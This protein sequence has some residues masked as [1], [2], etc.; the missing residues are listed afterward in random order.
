[1]SRTFARLSASKTALAMILRLAFHACDVPRIQHQKLVFLGVSHSAF[2]TPI[3]YAIPP[4]LSRLT[5]S[6]STRWAFAASGH[7]AAAP[8][9][10]V[11]NWRRLMSSMGSSPEPAV[12]AYRRLRMPRK[13]PQVLGASAAHQ[14]TQT[15]A[16]SNAVIAPYW[17]QR[18]FS[19]SVKP[20]RSSFGP[21]VT[22]RRD[23]QATT[24]GS[25]GLR[26]RSCHR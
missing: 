2:G 9:R 11:M 16:L 5:T 15:L 18:A 19:G 3:A 13:H 23:D 21:R 6:F 20:P 12:P 8:P 14:H 17:R 24:R 4:Q 25:R 10:S 26:R 7:V 1:M 22:G